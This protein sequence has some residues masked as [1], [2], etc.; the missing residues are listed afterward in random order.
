MQTLTYLYCM[1]VKCDSSI[2]YKMY[3]ISQPFI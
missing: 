1:S 3:E 2:L